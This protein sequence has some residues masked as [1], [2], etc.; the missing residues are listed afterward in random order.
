M[1]F[2]KTYGLVDMTQFIL[3]SLRFLGG[4]PEI[5][6]TE[7]GLAFVGKVGGRRVR[8]SVS[9]RREGSELLSEVEAEGDDQPVQELIEAV[10][11]RLVRAQGI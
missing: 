2:R 10:E 9:V 11:L 5:S 6:R 7:H 4:E 1:L 8:V 3:D